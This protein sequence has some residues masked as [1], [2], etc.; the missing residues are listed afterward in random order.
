MDEVSRRM[1]GVQVGSNLFARNDDQGREER[2]G[3]ALGPGCIEI[4]HRP[5]AVQSSL[6]PTVFTTLAHFCVS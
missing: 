2:C 6:M 1:W 5:Q 3:Q 4:A